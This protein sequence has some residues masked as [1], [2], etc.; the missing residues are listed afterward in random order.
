MRI[1]DALEAVRGVLLPVRD[2]LDGRVE[3]DA[4][5][6][7]C[8]RRGWTGALLGL[9]DEE[10]ARCEAEIAQEITRARALWIVAPERDE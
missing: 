7:W 10:L 8:E 2:I 4:P 1:A 5:P 3:D 6:A 9:D